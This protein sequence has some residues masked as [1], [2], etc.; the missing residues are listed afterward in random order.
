MKTYG[1]EKEQLHTYFIMALDWVSG[2]LHAPADL[3]P[4]EEP[5]LPIG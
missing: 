4:R 1:G 5:V 3:H 2:Q